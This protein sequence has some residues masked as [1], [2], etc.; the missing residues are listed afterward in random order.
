MSFLIMFPTV[1]FT[2]N[3]INS[4]DEILGVNEFVNYVQM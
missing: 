3:D 2:A 1:Y 4:L